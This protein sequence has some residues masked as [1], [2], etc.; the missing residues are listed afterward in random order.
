MSIG[1]TFATSS[2]RRSKARRLARHHR[3]RV[4]IDPEL[5][6]LRADAVLLEQ[7]FFNLLDNACKYAPAGSTVTVWARRM[8]TVVAIEVCDQGPGIPEEDREKV[9]DM[10]YRTQTGDAHGAGTGLGLAICRGII[11]AHG[12][13]IRIDSGLHGTG[14]C[15]V[16]RLPLPTD[17]GPGMPPEEESPRH[18]DS[19][20][21]SHRAGAA[22]QIDA[23]VHARCR[24]GL[25][26][27]ASGLGSPGG[28][29]DWH[30]VG[31]QR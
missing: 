8:P 21:R 12:G 24:I 20:V 2:P 16:M 11:E 3:I 23:Q 1:R 13:T 26:L 18:A 6:L 29:C 9:F 5:P 28:S 27:D 31:V 15:V 10:F 19:G 22:I 14:T 4:D 25:A 7:M 17:F 30:V